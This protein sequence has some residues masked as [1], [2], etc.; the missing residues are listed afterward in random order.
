MRIFEQYEEHQSY[1]FSF[2]LH[3][4]FFQKVGDSDL[5]SALLAIFFLTKKLWVSNL[6]RVRYLNT[7]QSSVVVV[8]KVLKTVD[9]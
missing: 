1:I 7:V 3:L 8:N 9:L 4:I 6:V 5:A 2:G